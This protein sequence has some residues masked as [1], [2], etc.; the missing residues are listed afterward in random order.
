MDICRGFKLV[1]HKM[2]GHRIYEGIAELELLDNS[3]VIDQRQHE[4]Y[5]TLRTNLV[6]VVAI[7]NINGTELPEAYLDKS[8]S[9]PFVTNMIKVG[10]VLRVKHADFTD[11]KKCI[12]FHSTR[13]GVMNLTQYVPTLYNGCKMWYYKNGHL[14]EKHYIINGLKVFVL[15]FYD[16]LFNTLKYT[17]TFEM[18]PNEAFPVIREYLYNEQENPL[19][20]YV[21]KEGRIVSK[22]VYDRTHSIESQFLN[23]LSS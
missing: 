20:Q 10:S 3:K 9:D 14:R 21:I 11:E 1:Y 19:A 18:Y 15:G 16:N 13:E 23:K 6:R 8:N 2:R 4:I 17:W 5:D 22:F 12:T 7:K